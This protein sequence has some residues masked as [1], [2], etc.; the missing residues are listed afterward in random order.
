M[1][2]GRELF[3]TFPWGNS[4]MPWT[5]DNPVLKPEVSTVRVT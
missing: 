1:D 4:S 5:G 2:L 3:H